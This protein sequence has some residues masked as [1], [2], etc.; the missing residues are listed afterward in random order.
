MSSMRRFRRFLITILLLK[1]FVIGFYITNTGN[2]RKS[3]DHFI[4]SN[5]FNAFLPTC[6]YKVSNIDKNTNN[7]DMTEVTFDV[8]IDRLTAQSIWLVNGGI[9]FTETNSKCAT[10]G[11]EYKRIAFI[12]PY[13]NRL[14]NLKIFLNN[15]HI[16]LSR[17]N[18]TYGIYL[19]EPNAGLKFNRGLLMNIGFAELLKDS[20]LWDCFVFHDIDLLPEDNRLYYT[21]D[22]E[23][24]LHYAVAVSRFKYQL[25]AKKFVF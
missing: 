6:T 22:P 5:I 12:I 9:S 19:I 13:R 3:I 17:H 10:F 1:I 18:I 14:K 23:Y 11:L 7:I 15:M 4:D 16:F 20:D 2:M 24:P 21:C 8:I 25:E